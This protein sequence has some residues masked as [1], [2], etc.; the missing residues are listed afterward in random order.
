MAI[1][2]FFLILFS[3]TYFQKHNEIDIFK[4]IN[5][6]NIS[7][8]RLDSNSKKTFSQNLYELIQQ[9]AKPFE[10][11][12]IC[13]KL[14][15]FIKKA[16]IQFTGAEFAV[17]I[18]LVILATEIFIYMLTLNYILA[19]IIGLSV[20]MS[21]YIWILIKIRKRRNSFTEQLGDCLLTFANAL[22]AGYSFQ[23]AMD[24]IAKEMESPI[25]QEFSRASTDIKMG[26]PLE[27]AL[28][29]MNSR[30][31]SSDFALVITAVLIQR[32][33][34]GNLAQILDTISDTIMERIRMKREINAL[35][36]QGRLS[37]VILL[38]LPFV[39]GIFM[40]TVNPDQVMILFEEPVGRMAVT[41]S[42]IMD[43]IGF[44]LIRRI[45]DIDV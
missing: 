15:S 23:Q 11:K 43:I 42:I 10:N 2:F 6:Y 29:Q 27:S 39:M 20:P 19:L 13:L 33:V 37:A 7:D 16:D 9:I 22:R 3:V 14:E 30:V 35:T 41:A 45:V 26:V 1:L 36:A 17:I 18:L 4:R 34:G 24:V 28:E 5:R 8:V 44:L 38:F 31:N 40:Y 32:E 21:V 25:S 12:K